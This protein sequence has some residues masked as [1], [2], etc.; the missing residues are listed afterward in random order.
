MKSIAFRFTEKDLLDIEN[1]KSS[2]GFETNIEAIRF[3][4][5]I[6][7]IAPKSNNLLSPKKRKY[8]DAYIEDWMLRNSDGFPKT[9]CPLHEHSEIW[10]CGCIIKNKEALINWF[11]E[12]YD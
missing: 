7:C 1:L 8:D 4:L 5:G 11:K 12:Q 2:H 3:A 9:K 10:S 6:A